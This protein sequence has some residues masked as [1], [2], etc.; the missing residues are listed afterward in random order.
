MYEKDRGRSEEML[1][2]LWLAK[3]NLPGAREDYAVHLVRFERHRASRAA[4]VRQNSRLEP[5]LSTFTATAP[6]SSKET[7]GTCQQKEC[8]MSRCQCQIAYIFNDQSEIERI[9][10]LEVLIHPPYSPELAPS[11]NHFSLT[12]AKLVSKEA[13]EN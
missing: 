10:F 9:F 12:G 7:A 6:T 11:D 3:H 13:C 5:V 8:R 4:A 1:H 2:S